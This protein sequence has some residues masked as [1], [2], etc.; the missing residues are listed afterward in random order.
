MVY[1]I[2]AINHA[3][4]IPITNTHMTYCFDCLMR[5]Y[6]MYARSLRVAMCSNSPD[7]LYECFKRVGRYND[8]IIEVWIYV[9]GWTQF[10][11]KE[12]SLESV[13]RCFIRRWIYY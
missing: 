11:G 2:N 9:L 10:Y 6:R 7:G 4:V 8:C 13:R 3:N 1:A 12:E 5:L